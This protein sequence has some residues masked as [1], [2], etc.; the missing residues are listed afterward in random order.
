[1][2]SMQVAID[3]RLIH[4]VLFNADR[5][6]GDLSAAKIGGTI[7][8]IFSYAVYKS[9]V[10]GG[11][12]MAL[13]AAALILA[14]VVS[15]AALL[16]GLLAAMT[17]ARRDEN[18]PHGKVWYTISEEGLDLRTDTRHEIVRW[19][20]V[21]D[22]QKNDRFIWIEAGDKVTR[23]IPRASCGSLEEFNSIWDSITRAANAN[24]R[25]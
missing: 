6:I 17:I 8:L 10:R 24:I 2:N 1:M 23:F 12:D 18:Q 15:V 19:A 21:S 13:L 3:V 14:F 25:P 22:V 9:Y 11:T 4:S 20:D 7:A 5:M 16:F